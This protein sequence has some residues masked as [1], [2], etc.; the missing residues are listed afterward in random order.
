M[1]PQ[2]RKILYAT[3]LSKNSAYA[4]RYAVGM[5]QKFDAKIVIVH[6]I[7]PVDRRGSIQVGL[8]VE[9]MMKA[10][11]QEERRED[12][13]EIR[14][15]IRTF[16][17]KMDTQ[18]GSPCAGLVSEILVSVG[19]AVEE[20]LE[21]ADGENCDVIVLGSHGKGVLRHTFLGSVAAAV[22][23]RSR[24]PV[25]IIPLPSAKTDEEWGRV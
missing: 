10:N 17:Q 21:A 12:I 11:K 13:Q 22:L 19:Y 23:E 9:E 3:D 2:I 4:F 14:K 5:A 6:V 8:E 18:V 25:L 24:R 7:P 1:I 16:C 20:I 15:N